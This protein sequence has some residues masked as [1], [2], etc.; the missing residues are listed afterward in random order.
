MNLVGRLSGN[1]ERADGLGAVERKLE[2]DIRD[3]V[4]D[5]NEARVQALNTVLVPYLDEHD[6]R[7]VLGA[8][9]LSAWVL[10]EVAEESTYQRVAS[11]PVTSG[12]K[13]VEG[14]AVQVVGEHPAAS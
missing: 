8:Q 11:H 12:A 10:G 3:G 5:I 2:R 13:G 1:K 9:G 14:G 6:V 4:I 7:A